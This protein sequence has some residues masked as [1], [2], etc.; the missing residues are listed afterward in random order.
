M[1]FKN[2][3][4]SAKNGNPSPNSIPRKEKAESGTQE[5]AK[6]VI[7]LMARLTGKAITERAFII[8]GQILN[9]GRCPLKN[10]YHDGGH[11]T[12]KNAPLIVAFPMP[13]VTTDWR[14][15]HADY[16]VLKNL[17]PITFHTMIHL[18]SIGYVGLV[19]LPFIILKSGPDK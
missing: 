7:V 3:A 2:Y 10:D 6:L 13:F 4:V 9:L 18:I 19:T 5:N 12:Q 14:K 17:K 1:E 11:P 8:V 16:A 15:N